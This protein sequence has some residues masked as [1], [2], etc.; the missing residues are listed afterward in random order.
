MNVT[1]NQI[2]KSMALSIVF[3][4]LLGFTYVESHANEAD[5]TQATFYVY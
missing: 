1:I 5:L 4:L 3:L 2:I